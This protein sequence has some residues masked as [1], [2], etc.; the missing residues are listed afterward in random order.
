MKEADSRVTQT[1][2]PRDNQMVRGKHKTMSI[3]SQCMWALSE[4]SSPR[5]ARPEYNNTYRNKEGDQKFYHTKVI[6]S[7]KEYINNSLKEIPDNAIKKKELN[8]AVQNLK[9]GV[10]TIKKTQMEANMEMENL[11][12]RSGITDVSIT[13]RIHLIAFSW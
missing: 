6:E 9:V 5:T 3:R 8:T 10:E 13:K 7:F 1:S 2:K 4:Y 11:E 12:K